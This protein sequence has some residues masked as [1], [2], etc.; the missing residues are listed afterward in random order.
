M[1]T[2]PDDWQAE[3]NESRT[4]KERY[5]RSS[6]RSPVP[7]E[8]R[9]ESFPGLA[10]YSI[11][12]EYR[13]TVPLTRDDDPETIT[14][15]TT[16]DGEQ[17]YR[18]VGTFD[19]TVETTPVSIA[20]Y[21]PTDGSDRLWVPFRDATSGSETYGAGRYIDLEPTEDHN[22]DGTWTLD[23]NRAYNPT[24][25]YNPAYECPLVPAENWLDVPIEVGEKD[26]PGNFHDG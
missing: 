2:T 24:C 3:I 16:A 23:L 26:F 18:R 4:N 17:T 25:A 20:A 15:E 5:F 10:Y 14:V 8:F 1:S 6:D 12:P 9:G 21:E 19:I 13:F 22:D 7:P 11:D